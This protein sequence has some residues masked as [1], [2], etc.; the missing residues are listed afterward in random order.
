MR[1]ALPSL[2]VFVLGLWLMVAPSLLGY[3]GTAGETS[4]RLV[5]PLVAAVGFVAA[6]AITRSVRWLN[7]AA[8]AWLVIGP[9]LVGVPT[10]AAVNSL[11]VGVLVG[12]LTPLGKPDPDRF[13]G[14]WRTLWKPER[15]AGRP[16]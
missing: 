5:G 3:V 10:A 15:L 6:S 16:E 11:V 14:G 1:R 12:V 4:D 9:W 2:L 13:G 8:A 7:L